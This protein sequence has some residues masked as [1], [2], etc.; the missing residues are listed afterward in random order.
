[1][2][3]YAKT[4]TTS[5]DQYWNILLGG[6]MQSLMVYTIMGVIIFIKSYF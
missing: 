1:M 3:Q 4:E 5:S 6:A 2:S